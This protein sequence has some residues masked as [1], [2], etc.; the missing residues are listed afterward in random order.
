MIEVVHKHKAANCVAE[1]GTDLMECHLIQ[2]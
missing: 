2:E 1:A